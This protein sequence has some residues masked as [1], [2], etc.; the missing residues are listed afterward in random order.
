VQ[1]E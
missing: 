1:P